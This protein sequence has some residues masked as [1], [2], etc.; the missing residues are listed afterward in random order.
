M[1][2]FTTTFYYHK[3]LKIRIEKDLL[4]Y[5][6]WH[7]RK[8]T[9]NCIKLSTP[10]YSPHLSVTLP[11]IHGEAICKASKKYAGEKVTV[12][13]T[14]EIIKGGSWFTNFWLPFECDRATSIKKELGVKEKNFLGFHLTVASDKN[15]I[16][17]TQSNET[18]KQTKKTPLSKKA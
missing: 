8:G 18:N 12:T 3:G 16:K 6:Y 11:N 10:L 5:Y 15:D 2:T 17:N 1:F 13:Y 4:E 14:G 7:V 9:Y